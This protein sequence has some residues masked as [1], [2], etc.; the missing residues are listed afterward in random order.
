MR[1]KGTLLG[2]LALLR[3]VSCNIINSANL[4]GSAYLSA[5]LIETYHQ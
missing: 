1:F 4:L 3:T 5:Y 2:L